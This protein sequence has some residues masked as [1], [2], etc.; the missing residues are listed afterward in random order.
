MAY[1]ITFGGFLLLGGRAADLLGRRRVFVVGVT[2]SPP[3][4]SSAGSRARRRAH[5]SARGAGPRR[6]DRLAR[7]AG[8]HHD[9]LRGRR[10]AEQGARDLGRDRRWRRSGRRP[11]RRHPHEVPRLGVDLLRQRPGGRARPRAHAASCARVAPSADVASTSAARPRSRP[12]LHCSSMRSRKRR[13]MAGEAA[14]RWARS[15]PR[16]CCS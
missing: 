15:W 7:D 9:D 11:L 5:R 12:G 10:R 6:G 3:R 14:E 13:T 8:D 16:S 1:T 4:R 2:S